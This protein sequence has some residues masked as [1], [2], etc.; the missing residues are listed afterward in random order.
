M[1]KQ[2]QTS[3]NLKLSAKVAE[4][5]TKNP[6]MVK[7]FKGNLSFVVFSVKDSELNK[8]NTNLVKK[9]KQEGKNVIKVQQTKN[10]DSPWK[11]VPLSI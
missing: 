10:V 5:I 6:E 7:D 4:Y 2:A 3:K 1:T 11:F 9:L 8:A